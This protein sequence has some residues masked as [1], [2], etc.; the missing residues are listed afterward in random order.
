MGPKVVSGP[1]V[2]FF[3]SPPDVWRRVCV[4]KEE[5]EAE[6]RGVHPRRHRH[7][8]GVLLGQG[9]SP[10]PACP[11]DPRNL[12]VHARGGPSPERGPSSSLSSIKEKLM[13]QADRFSE[14][15]V[16]AG[17]SGLRPGLLIFL[18]GAGRPG[19]ISAAPPLEIALPQMLR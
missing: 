7:L 16:S 5:T 14:E 15:E 2:H 4:T 18:E 19:P 10:Q 13:T 9:S 11:H 6:R 1:Q 8:V 3:W 17:F 12:R